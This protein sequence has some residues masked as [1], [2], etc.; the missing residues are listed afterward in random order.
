MTQTTHT[1]K[2]N[3][4]RYAQTGEQMGGGALEGHLLVFY[5][6]LDKDISSITTE[7]DW[8]QNWRPVAPDDCTVCMGTGHDHIKGNK[9]KP[10]GHCYGLG[11]VR[12]DGVA[13]ADR[14][15]LATVANGIIKR[16]QIELAQLRPIAGD[17]E[18]QA[19]LHQRQQDAIGKSEQAWREGRGHGHGGQRHTGD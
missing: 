9:D 13:P 2:T 4:G 15:D 8:R 5:H 6:D 3:G 17:P 7:T 16:Q 19:L 1:H 10:C 12:D 11:K 14:W 18:V